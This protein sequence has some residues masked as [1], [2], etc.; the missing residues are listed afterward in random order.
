MDNKKMDKKQK[1]MIVDLIDTYLAQRD[2]GTILLSDQVNELDRIRIILL[3]EVKN[4]E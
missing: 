2:D 1:L 3:N 4:E